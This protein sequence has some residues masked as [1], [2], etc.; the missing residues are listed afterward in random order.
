METGS[1]FSLNLAPI[2]LRVDLRGDWPNRHARSTGTAGTGKSVLFVCEGY[3]AN[4]AVS[5]YYCVSPTVSILQKVVKMLHNKTL[6]ALLKKAWLFHQ[7][8]CG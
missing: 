1:G 5:N 4:G 2:L 6:K 7:N 8:E 3:D